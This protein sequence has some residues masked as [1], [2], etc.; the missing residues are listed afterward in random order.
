MYVKR[1]KWESGRFC[2]SQIV[3]DFRLL[4]RQAMILK[5]AKQVNVDSADQFKLFLIFAMPVKIIKFSGILTTGNV[6]GIKK[7]FIKSF[8]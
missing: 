3:V 8:F 5:A 7:S 6:N 2:W 1:L 4:P